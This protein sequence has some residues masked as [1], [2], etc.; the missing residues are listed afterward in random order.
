MNKKSTL[1]LYIITEQ[2]L[3]ERCLLASHI[4]QALKKKYRCTTYNFVLK[5]SS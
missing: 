4:N 3:P 2:L 5:Y 1:L